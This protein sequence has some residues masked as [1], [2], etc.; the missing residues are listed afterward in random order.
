MRNIIFTTIINPPLVFGV[1][2]AFAFLILFLLFVSSILMKALFGFVGM[3]LSFA[4]VI[5]FYLYG[6]KRTSSDP[7]WLNVVLMAFLFESKR[8]VEFISR[9]FTKRDKVFYR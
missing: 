2:G 6:K 9:Y 5:Y 7:Y 8:P 4:A 1:T 3:V